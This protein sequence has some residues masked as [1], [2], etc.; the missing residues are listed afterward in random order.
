MVYE[1]GSCDLFISASDNEIYRLN[2]ELGQF[3][4]PY[5]LSF[6]GCNKLSVNPSH[7]LLACGGESASCDFF[8]YRSRKRVSHLSVSPIQDIEVWKLMLR[9]TL[10]YSIWSLYFYLECNITK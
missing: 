9:I 7:P 6:C 5:A 4:E 8:D 10:Y 2:L 3:K 1:W